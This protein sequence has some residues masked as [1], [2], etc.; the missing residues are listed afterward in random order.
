MSNT[1]IFET[2]FS[3][4]MQVTRYNDPVYVAQASFEERANLRDGQVVNR[5][6]F[7]RFYAD[8]YT[9]GSDMTEQGYIQTA[10]TLTVNDIPALLLRID[11]FDEL[12]SSY[13][14]QDR[15]ATDGVRAVNEYV[16]A[17][18]LA[19]VA[20]A[21]STVDAGDVGGSSGSAITL[22]STN[23][24]QAFA[25]AR[26]K[27]RLQ[28]V[29]I[30]GKADPRIS[31]G[32]MK[33]GGQMGFANM[34]P[35]MSE[36]LQFSLAGR[37][38][39]DGDM[40][41][42]NGYVAKYFG[43]DGYETN[44]GYWTAVLSLA[45]QPTDGDT[46]VINGVTFTFKTTLGSTAGNVLIGASADTARANLAALINDPSTTTAQGVAL[47]STKDATGT[48]DQDRVRNITATND[49]TADTLTL[50]AS[51]YG[52]VVVSETLTDATDAFTSEVS[53]NLFGQKGA[54]DMVMQDEIKVKFSD[55]PKQHGTY[56]KPRCLFGTKS[57]L[58]GRNAMVDVQVNSAAWV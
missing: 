25:A 34:N 41:G 57:F 14:M 35:Y 43:F 44:N 24:L 12:Q 38:T 31:R 40:I 48:S 45:T 54:V 21:T 5:P 15:L 28:N 10:E 37:E 52:Y 58:E 7:G 11:D 53:H 2:K 39:S 26:R 23:I 50:A 16:D 46:V 9:R 42:K 3:K 33:P 17:T 6:Q 51:G 30:T 29:D 27:L 8:T 19:E 55:I 32:N 36:Q 56:V 4:R 1:T 13:D 47:D 18:Y 22:D 20:N 49:N